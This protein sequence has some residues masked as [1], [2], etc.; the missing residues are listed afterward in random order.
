MVLPERLVSL[1]GA[2]RW[3]LSPCSD[4]TVD[5][6]GLRNLVGKTMSN[7]INRLF[8]VIGSAK[9]GTTTVAHWLDQHPGMQLG[10]KKEPCY[11]TDFATRR[12]QGPGA[13]AFFGSLVTGFDQ[14]LE[15]FPGLASDIWAVD[16]SVDYIWSDGALERIKTFASGREVKILAIVRDP[17]ARAVS[18]Y[19][20]T[21]RHGWEPLSFRASL[22]AEPE[23]TDAG[24]QPLFRHRRRSLIH[25]D[26]MRAH[27]LFGNDLMILDY[28]DLR[29]PDSVMRRIC[30]FLGIASIAVEG[31]ERQNESYLPR[32]RL[33]RALLESGPI[34][35]A[36]RHLLPPSLRRNIRAGLYVN[37]RS[38]ETVTA[39]ER[40]Q[41]RDGISDEIEACLRSDL[42]PTTGWRCTLQDAL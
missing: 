13:D 23:R 1:G 22:A 4:G 31:A 2:A 39:D 20:H 27:T 10:I 18:E 6:F 7:G 37:A 25:D 38:L 9:A 35:Q 5:L 11:F 21:L 40:A 30:T 16:A 42:I 14:Y 12:W 19:N 36:A 8:V 34:R 32:N 15:N 28:G 29:E 41:F 24:F 17:V 26:L 33:A 3:P